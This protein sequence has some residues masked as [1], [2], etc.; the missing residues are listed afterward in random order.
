MHIGHGDKLFKTECVFFHLP[1]FFN[2]H[3]L[4]LPAP[5]DMRS[6]MQLVIMLTRSPTKDAKLKTRSGLAARL[7]KN[8]TTNLKKHNP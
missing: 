7:K 6:I 5:S 2:S 3:M 8:Y 4:S 1:G